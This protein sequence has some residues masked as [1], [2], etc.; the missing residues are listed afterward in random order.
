LYCDVAERK[1]VCYSEMTGENHRHNIMKGNILILTFRLFQNDFIE[2]TSFLQDMDFSILTL[3]L[4][5]PTT[6][7]ARINP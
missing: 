1:Q 2:M 6:V 7:G 5:A 4:L 3:N